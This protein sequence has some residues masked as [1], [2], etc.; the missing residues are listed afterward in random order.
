MGFNLSDFTNKKDFIYKLNG[1]GETSGYVLKTNGTTSY[2][3]AESGG[4]GGGSITVQPSESNDQGYFAGSITNN[5]VTT[6]FI[7]RPARLADSELESGQGVIRPYLEFDFSGYEYQ[8]FDGGI[9][10]TDSAGVYLYRNFD[11]G[12]ENPVVLV[13]IVTVYRVN[14]ETG[15]NEAI[16]CLALPYDVGYTLGLEN[17]YSEPILVE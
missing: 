11:V 7:V 10:W 6:S 3:G 8:M 14:S 5:N 9:S 16:P 12:E 17:L 13:P 1:V 2:W 4:G 15:T